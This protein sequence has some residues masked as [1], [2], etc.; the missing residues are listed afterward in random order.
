MSAKISLAGRG[1]AQSP[2]NHRGKASSGLL[3]AGKSAVK[4]PSSM[5]IEVSSTEERAVKRAAVPEL[6]GSSSLS[7]PNTLLKR[8]SI[9]PALTRACT[10]A[11]P[12]KRF[13]FAS[14]GESIHT[15]LFLLSSFG[16]SF[17]L[18]VI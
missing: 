14:L 10:T 9:M 18:S 12:P 8:E 11:T 7:R 4:R 16:V 3:L 2:V 17:I 1:A 6:E 15:Y 5:T 13:K